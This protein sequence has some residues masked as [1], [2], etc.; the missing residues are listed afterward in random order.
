M[1]GPLATAG[2]TANVFPMFFPCPCQMT[3]HDAALDG[4]FQTGRRRVL[5][6]VTGHAMTEPGQEIVTHPPTVG[7]G[8]METESRTEPVGMHRSQEMHVHG[9]NSRISEDL[10]QNAIL[11]S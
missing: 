7:C 6:M 2:V 8:E 5:R 11:D 1:N 10:R 4:R 9:S 3:F